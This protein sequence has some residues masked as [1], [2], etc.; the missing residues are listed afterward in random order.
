MTF[1][2]IPI[3]CQCS[4]ATGL[5]NAGVRCCAYPFDVVLSYPR[6]IGRLLLMLL[7]GA[8]PEE[9]VGKEYFAH[10]RKSR[11]HPTKYTE[12]Y[13]SC[14]S[15]IAYTDMEH[16]ITF[17]HESNIEQS[18]ENFKRRFIRLRDTLVDART[19]Q[20]PVIFMYS[21]PGGPDCHYSLDNG[22]ELTHGAFEELKI[23]SGELLQKGLN[24]RIVYF[25]YEQDK[26]S[27]GT[28]DVVRFP[29]TSH[30]WQCAQRQVVKWAKEELPTFLINKF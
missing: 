17:P 29:V 28:I 18:M 21:S 25:T 9:M 14:D 22:P 8:D 19:N 16:L 10:L 13:I 3:G 20:I 24:H 4:V 12:H 30:S 5:K 1:H 2:C 23:L 27:E 7:D 11:L 6:E 26:Q 15:G